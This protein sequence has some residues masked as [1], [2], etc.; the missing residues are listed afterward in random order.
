MAK[1]SKEQELQVVDAADAAIKKYLTAKRTHALAALDTYLNACPHCRAFDNELLMPLGLTL[2]VS[3]LE[4]VLDVFVNKGV[5]IYRCPFCVRCVYTTE[6]EVEG[7][8][9]PDRRIH[10]G[11][12]PPDGIVRRKND[13]SNSW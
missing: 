6:H 12:I 9:E 10:A 13:E 1:V 3:K 7:Q 5:L 4:T 2:D 8:N 11:V